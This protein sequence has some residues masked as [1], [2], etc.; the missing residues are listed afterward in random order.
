MN[1]PGARLRSAA[2][3]RWEAPARRIRAGG[4]ATDQLGHA[5]TRTSAARCVQHL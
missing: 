5:R 3:G 4:R 2:A 1:V